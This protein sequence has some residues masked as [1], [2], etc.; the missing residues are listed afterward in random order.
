VQQWLHECASVLGYTYI[1]WLRAVL[2]YALI[3]LMS[4]F[5]TV[6]AKVH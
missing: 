4:L 5:E 3:S 6:V 2:D 1:T